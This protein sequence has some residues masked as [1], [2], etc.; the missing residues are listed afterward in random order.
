M[1]NTV[2]KRI[3]S[4]MKIRIIYFNE[5]YKNSV[6]L[7]CYCSLFLLHYGTYLKLSK[8]YLTPSRTGSKSSSKMLV[9]RQDCLHRILAIS[10][11]R[12]DRLRNFMSMT[13]PA[14]H[15]FW[16]NFRL[17]FVRF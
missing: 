15:H 14:Y 7:N 4:Y 11:G 9:G 17:Q 12:Q 3:Q 2:F 13:L 8:F 6:I 1:R 16:R 10:R 5:L